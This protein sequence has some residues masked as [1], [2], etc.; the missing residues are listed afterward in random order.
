MTDQGLV[1]KAMKAIREAAELGSLRGARTMKV[2]TDWLVVANNHV[3]ALEQDH[4]GI[5]QQYDELR[6][7][8]QQ[9]KDHLDSRVREVT[10]LHEQIVRLNREL[11]RI[12]WWVRR[13]CGASGGQR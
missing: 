2:A 9:S 11:N 4:R 3:A 5:R 13:W 7:A 6:K 12:P 1:V 8:Y 10:A